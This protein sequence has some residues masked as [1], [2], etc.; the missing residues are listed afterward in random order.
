M[1]NFPKVTAFRSNKNQSLREIIVRKSPVILQ[2]FGK[3]N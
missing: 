3:F 2:Q 1:L